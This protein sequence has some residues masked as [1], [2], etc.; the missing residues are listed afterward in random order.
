MTDEDRVKLYDLLIEGIRCHWISAELAGRVVDLLEDE[1]E[2][3][4]ADVAWSRYLINRG[5]VT[6]GH[7]S[8][9]PFSVCLGQVRREYQ[10]GAA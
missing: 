5:L 9:K 3:H 1:V 4:L 6:R 7:G 2:S 10:E 8:D